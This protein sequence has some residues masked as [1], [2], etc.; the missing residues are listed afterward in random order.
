MYC[1]SYVN[2]L[3]LTYGKKLLTFMADVLF[4]ILGILLLTLLVVLK[5]D[6]TDSLLEVSTVFMIVA[7]TLQDIEA[8][9]LQ[10]TPSWPLFV[11]VVDILL[12]CEAPMRATVGVVCWCCLHLVVIS[13]ESSYSF[14]L[15]DLEYQQY[16]HGERRLLG[17]PQ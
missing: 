11:I 1:S 4:L 10:I 17:R 16:S 12:V 2:T 5:R 3:S 9:M 13:I 15:F 14:G 7:I 6:M 8:G